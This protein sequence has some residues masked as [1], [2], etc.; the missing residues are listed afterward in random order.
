MYSTGKNSVELQANI[1]EAINFYLEDHNQE[2][3]ENNIDL[4]ID[5]KQFFQYHRVINS[6]YLAERIGMNSTLLSQS[7]Q[8]KKQP[9]DRQV[10]KIIF[11]LN[12][13]GKELSELKL[14][15]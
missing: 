4:E 8:G 7:V 9:S 14:V 5:L 3:N 12:E 13:I 6:K 11:G 15:G 2:I 10:A 1:L